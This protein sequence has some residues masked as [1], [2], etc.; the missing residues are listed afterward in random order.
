MNSLV[1]RLHTYV[2]NRYNKDYSKD[3][4]N[5]ITGD[6]T[7]N[8]PYFSP[9]NVPYYSVETLMVEGPDY[10]H[11]SLSDNYSYWVWLEAVY[12]KLTGDYKGVEKAWDNLEKHLIPDSNNQ[13]GNNRYNPSSPT[14]YSAQYDDI[15][16]YPS[17]YVFL[18]DIV[19]KDPIAKE[20]QKAYG[21]WDMYAMHWMIDGDNWYGYGQQGDGV[22]KPSFINT[23]RRGPSETV[24]KT[25]P[26]PCWE[27]MKWGGRNGFL[28]LFT[29]DNS[30]VKEWRYIST[31][32][33]SSRAIQAA[34]FAYVW[35]KSDGID[36]SSIASKASKLGDYL[37]YAHYDKY[38]KTIGNCIGYA[39]CPAGKKKD[40]AHYLIS[41][42]FSWGGGLTGDWAWRAGSSHIHSAYQNPLTAW[43]LSTKSAFKPKSASGANDWGVSLS[44][45]LE[46]LRWVQSAEGVLAAGATNSWK[47]SYEQPTNG[48]S[49]FYGMYYE[50]YP[51][52]DNLVMNVSLDWVG[53][54]GVSMERVCSLYFLTGDKRA[55]MICSKWVEWIKNNVRISRDEIIHPTFIALEGSPDDW[56]PSNFYNSDLNKSL[57]GVVASEGIDVGAIA[58][59]MK[60]VLW[61]SA[62]VSDQEGL[63]LYSDVMEA[64]RSYRDNI[65]YSTNEGCYS[66]DNFYYEE[67]YIP[68]GWVGKNAQGAIIKSG[69]NF[70]DLRPKYKQDDNWPQVE[71]YINGGNVPEI[72]YHRFRDQVEIMVANGLGY[73]ISTDPESMIEP[74]P[75]LSQCSNLII[76]Q[77]YKCCNAGC[78][79]IKT[80]RKGTWGY[81]NGQWCGCETCFSNIIK[82]GYK[83]CSGCSTVYYT[84]EDGDWGFEN[85]EWCGI[86]IEC[87]ST[88]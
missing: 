63:S 56:N 86:P 21:T 24:W 52:S 83:C 14:T 75:E 1:P 64:L 61:Y 31:S 60:A 41:W 13:P 16:K 4:Y 36:L 55:E 26:H 5:L 18:S 70:I 73:I 87:Y 45:Q 82:Q 32:D 42:Y 35:A 23:Y 2:I 9:E 25:V 84:D 58:S 22:S 30:F 44:R 50:S 65:G 54:Q 33:A 81:E 6:G 19:G 66:Y 28:D 15:E 47:G 59:F 3:I 68:A 76:A 53:V 62:K 17:Q 57:H 11:E 88:P 43:I 85:G 8:S 51:Q 29:I 37:R 48:V 39:D 72:N 20:L 80:N 67:V 12:G 49:T 46:F 40:S 7:Y 78:E 69:V 34:Y 77:G 38:F 27:S 79:I 10:G 71:E 74:E